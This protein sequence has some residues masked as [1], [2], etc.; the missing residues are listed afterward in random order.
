MI[1]ILELLGLLARVWSIIRP[2]WIFRKLR[3]R[4]VQKC[5]LDTVIA[6]FWVSEKLTNEN[7]VKHLLNT[8]V[9]ILF[10]YFLAIC[11]PPCK[12]GGTCTRPYT[13]SCPVGRF[14]GPNCDKRK[15]FFICSLKYIFIKVN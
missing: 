8:L 11:D 5:N 6:V 9:F 2:L 13:C 7:S 14:T 3:Q 10:R 12:H 1:T 4:L 15:Q